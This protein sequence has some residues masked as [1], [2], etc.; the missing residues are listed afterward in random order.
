MGRPGFREAL[1]ACPGGVRLLAVDEA[2]CISKWG[3][4][5]RP[6]YRTVGAF[7]REL[8]SPPTIALT[9]TATKTVRG[10][11]R[12]VL[13]FSEDQ[14]PLYAA[15][16]DRPNLSLHA[17]EVW[18]D[19][20]KI[21]AVRTLAGDLGGTG[22]VYF[23][24]IKDMERMAP[25]IARALPDRHVEVY[26]GRLDPR[27]KKRLSRLFIEAQPEDGLTLLATNAFG[28]GVDKPDIRFIAH[29]QT[30][31]SV[32][33]YFQEV[34]RAGRDGDPSRCELLYAQDDLAIQQQFT[35]WA[36]P[37]AD[38]LASFASWMQTLPPGALFDADDARLAVIGKG[39]A[40]GRSGGVVEYALTALEDDGVIERGGEPGTYRFVRPLH[41]DEID[42]EE[43]AAKR[44]RDLR[45]LLEVVRMVRSDDI[46]AFVS[47]YFEL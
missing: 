29:A 22:I 16:V 31:G 24:L 30:P 7:R 27:E 47:A 2:H 10:D 41:D 5:L 36:N 45:R 18:S 25:E 23:S 1:A 4:D 9:A 15:P 26:H 19:E 38:L 28:M 12:E 34:G 33:A 21:N 6:A 17:R 40:H 14:M 32:E 42:P 13:G 3:H 8:G 44:E 39:H 20:E 46:A 37:P 11:I 43:I 35:E